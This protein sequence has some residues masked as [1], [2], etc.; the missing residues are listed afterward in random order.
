MEESSSIRFCSVLQPDRGSLLVRAGSGY[1]I[2]GMALA[3]R[4][5]ETERHSAAAPCAGTH[6]YGVDLA[7]MVAA[8]PGPQAGARAAALPIAPGGIGGCGSGAHR[9][10]RRVPERCERPGVSWRHA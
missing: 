6:V 5:A 3:A 9:S 4:R 8:F 10:S 1:R 2:D 7:G